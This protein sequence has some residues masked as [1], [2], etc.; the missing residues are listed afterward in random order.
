MNGRNRRGFRKSAFIR[1]PENL[2]DQDTHRN[3]GWL[4][5]GLFGV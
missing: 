3:E 4:S 5:W 2:R 1:K